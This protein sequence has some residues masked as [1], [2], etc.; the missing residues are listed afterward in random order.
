AIGKNQLRVATTWPPFFAGLSL[1]SWHAGGTCLEIIMGERRG[2]FCHQ[3]YP[4]D[5]RRAEP[6]IFH[7]TCLVVGERVGH[8]PNPLGA[9]HSPRHRYYSAGGGGDAHGDAALLATPAPL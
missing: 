1:E 3:T 6:G 4:H 7:T 2:L 9:D 8:A 5:C